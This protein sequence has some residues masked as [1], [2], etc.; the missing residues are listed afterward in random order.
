MT[1]PVWSDNYIVKSFALLPNPLGIP[2]HLQG[3]PIPDPL[4][5]H[6]GL[7]QRHVFNKTYDTNNRLVLGR[8]LG[9]VW[10][11]ENQPK[12]LAANERVAFESSW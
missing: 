12:F 9:T 8:F 5:Q 10:P 11:Q 4:Q 6:A 7:A 3:M 2:F 1:G